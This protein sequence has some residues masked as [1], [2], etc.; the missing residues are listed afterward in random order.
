MTADDGATTRIDPAAPARSG[1]VD[2]A[3]RVA[4]I[5]QPQEL[6]RLRPAWDELAVAAGRPACLSAWQLACWRQQARPGDALRAV[7]VHDGGR[8]VALAPY[9]A[10]RAAG[11]RSVRRLLAA[12]VTHRVE[13]LLAPDAPSAAARLLAR[14]LVTGEPRPD[15]LLLDAADGGGEWLA[16]LRAAWPGRRPPW[17]LTD[18]RQAAPCASLE[19]DDYNAW[20][21]TK[22]SNFRQQ[23]RRFRRRLLAAGGTI[24]MTRSVDELERDVEAFVRL[25]HA[26]WDAR[27]GSTLSRDVGS[28]LCD[29]GRELLEAER[30]RLWI[31][32]LDGQPV[33]AQVFLAAGPEVLYWNGG[34]DVGAARLRP[35]LVGMLAA[36]EDCIGR[37]E[38]LLDLGG[39]AH[40]Y[41][42]RI[43]DGERQLAWSV[44]V[45]RDRRYPRNRAAL[46]PRQLEGLARRGFFALP[47]AQQ[48]RVRALLRR[49]GAGAG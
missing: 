40:E 22:S 20:L 7:T 36:I 34:F 21:A 6:E 47:E 43:A 28:L 29:A 41:K 17:V 4:V 14:A 24:R 30:F 49:P 35:A 33:S 18:R 15:A 12:D 38:R 8:L 19:Y 26:R 27:G 45:P 16:T 2:D 32:E 44:L 13:P 1:D 42:L 48:Q 5:E 10:Q 31:V 37:G 39:G 25:H 9:A 11:G 46:V 3:L 23:A